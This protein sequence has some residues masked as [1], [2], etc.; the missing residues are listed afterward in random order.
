M[1]EIEGL[2]ETLDE[3]HWARLVLRHGKWEVVQKK[4][5][6]VM[7]KANVEIGKTYQAKVSGKLAKV[8]IT[9]ESRFGGWDGI[10]VTTNKKVRIK[11]AQR[12]RLVPQPKVVVDPNQSLRE[13][14]HDLSKAIGVQM[15]PAEKAKGKKAPKEKKEKRMSGLDMVAQV[16]KEAGEPL[17]AK[18]MTERAIAKGW[19]TS[20]KTPAATVYAAII[21]EIA[22]KGKES[23]FVKVDKG[24]FTLA[25]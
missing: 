23:R 9:G 12:L 11:S 18:T 8:R 14:A 5:E 15:I 10:N 13:S 6:A 21:R 19:K 1:F 24:K 17:D 22:A 3:R 7:K 2:R 25:K 4:E 20:G 16:L